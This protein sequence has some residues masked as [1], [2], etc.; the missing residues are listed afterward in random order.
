MKPSILLIDHPVGRRDDR[1]SA[2][3]REMGYGIE[4]CSPGKG[5]TLPPVDNGHGAVVVYGGAESVNEAESKPY[6]REEIDWI[7]RWA[8]SGRPFL[9]ICLGAQMLARSLGAPV[10]RHRDGLHEIGYVKVEPT[11]VA[12]DFMDEAMH[13]Y[14]WHNEG[15]DVPAC[16][17]LLASG[18]VFPNQAFRYGEKAYGIQ[19]HPEV[20]RPVMQRWMHEAGHMLEEPG[21]HPSEVQLADSERFDAP[22]E[23]W[24]RRF[25]AGWLS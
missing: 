20:S 10:N 5:D 11:P 21:A 1:A 15:F 12:E 16:A 17:E 13:V 25:L 23:A 6:I 22:M 2:I 18:P 24:L 8:E 4:W 19:F 9:G 7:G 14:H 3:L